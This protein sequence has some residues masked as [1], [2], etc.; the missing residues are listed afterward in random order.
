VSANRFH[1]LIPHRVR[2]ILLVSSP[3]DAFILEE[4]GRLSE[5]LYNEFRALDLSAPPRVHQASSSQQAIKL[6]KGARFDLILVMS[7]LADESINDFARQVRQTYPA[8][9]IVYLALDPRE[10]EDAELILDPEVV[11]LTFVWTGDS[12]VLL[13]LIKMVEDRLNAEHDTAAGVRVIMVVEDSPNYYSTF[14]GLL[15]EELMTQAKSLYFEG[16]N[17]LQRK[18]YTRS[19]PKI[20]LAT[21]YEAGVQL[22]SKYRKSLLALICDVRLPLEGTLD[23]KAGFAFAK[24]IRRDL[25]DLPVLFQSAEEEN[26]A[27]AAEVGGL[28]VRKGTREVLP[29]VKAFL[30]DHLG[31]GDFVFRMPDG[32][33]IA[34]ASDVGEL[35]DHVARVPI[36]SIEFHAAHDQFSI[37]LMARSE[38]ELAEQLR[39]KKISDFESIEAL[40]RHLLRNLLEARHR[41]K[42]G[43]V[44]DF[45]PEHLAS[46]D[47]VRIGEGSL[48]A[49]ARGVAFLHQRLSELERRRAS[50][51]PAR[52][53]RSVVLTTSVFDDFVDEDLVNWALACDDDG[54]IARRFLARPLPGDLGSD[55]ERIVESFEGPLAVRSSS[56]LEDSAQQPFAG[57]YATLMIPNSARDL[58]QRRDELADAIRLVWASTFYRNACAYREAS[59][60]P[61][62]REKMAVMIQ[63]LVGSRHGDRF[64]PTISG[65]ALT[66]NFYPIGP[67]RPEHGVVHLALGLGRMIVDGGLSLRFSPRHPEVLPQVST[68]KMAL[69]STQREFYAVDL[70]AGAVDPMD[71]VRTYPL[72]VAE[73]DG[74]LALVGSV[75]SRV[76]ERLI[77]DLSTPGPRVVSFHNV[78]KHHALPLVETVK[79]LMGIA[80]QGLGREVEIEF[81][82]QMEDGPGGL[83]C[84]PELIALQ[85][86]P[87]TARPRLAARVERRY[88]RQDLLCAS[89][90]ALGQGVESAIRDVLYVKP[91]TWDPAHNRAIAQEIGRFNADLRRDDRPYLL[92]GPGRWGSADEWLGIPVQWSQISHVRAMVEA[93]PGTYQVEPS[94][95]THFFQNITSLR[96]GYFT[97]PP[98]SP[99]HPAEDP[100]I[101]TDWLDLQAAA[102][103]TE[104]LRHVRF[105]ETLTTVL[106]GRDRG[107]LIVKPGAAG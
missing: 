35:A 65:V 31:F 25:P 13:G 6:L 64:Y 106:H 60:A 7:S 19:R 14:L 29:A 94:Q 67:Q 77:E 11:D 5:Q 90:N 33:E 4:D 15:Y 56:L 10:L 103:E 104:F 50:T 89:L 22:Y 45:R 87:M 51:L 63:C 34:R 91:Q 80:R 39:P 88:A 101:D 79:R 74:T 26:A 85:V 93:S 96:I 38:F 17:E 76:D 83:W 28:F 58:D 12:S 55:L 97:L 24:R 98:G 105:D 36:E 69:K 75:L 102:G 54:E 2:E 57:I 107:G 86:R 41:G 49:K 99:R 100:F 71:A 43:I 23:P 44:T 9:P 70:T 47:F 73:A 59:N 78:L 30:A 40:R 53:P 92:I 68:P 1:D 3:Y 95:G 48:G 84:N 20:L 62:E 37:W 52:V 82:L 42:S 8:K 72:K 32:R 16:L 18:L 81:A 21:S 46:D 61:T 27:E 66:R